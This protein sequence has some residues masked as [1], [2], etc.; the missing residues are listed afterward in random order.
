MEKKNV[1]TKVALLFSGSTYNINVVVF[2]VAIGAIST[3][4][5]ATSTQLSQITNLPAL[6]MIPAVLISA[7]LA[8]K[9]SKK[10]ILVVAWILF[11]ASGFVASA[12]T[13][14]EMLLV[15]RAFTGFAIGLISSIPRAMIAQLYPQE[16]GQLNGFQTSCTAAVSFISSLVAGGLAAISWKYPIYLFFLGIVFLVLILIFIPRVPAEK[17]E[18]AEEKKEKKPFGAMVW[19]TVL[20]GTF[21]FMLFVPIQTKLTLV[22]LKGGFGDSV[23]AGYARAFLTIGS[24]VGG[25]F[26]AAL[27]KKN[28]KAVLILALT[29]ATVSYYFLSTTANLYVLFGSIL[30]SGMSTLGMT[31]PWFG[32][33]IAQSVDRSR[34]TMLLSTYT[35]LNYLSQFLT[36]Y[37]VAGME[38][39]AGNSN[40]TTA[41]FGVTICLLI[42]LIV[43][44]AIFYIVPKKS[45][46]TTGVSN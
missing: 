15:S 25:I 45:T 31:L 33:T 10:D 13:S 24:V 5:S 27:A 7:K 35:I 16:I 32:S 22:I 6:F 40:P 36:T 29:L 34:V 11:M 43:V 23:V 42:S 2:G 9:F 8:E 20:S 30:I 46:A 17:K 1:M 18:Y 19:L 21:M 37:I 41:L 39:I 4:F 12:S 3:N 26:F 28:K 14:I 44:I 38:K